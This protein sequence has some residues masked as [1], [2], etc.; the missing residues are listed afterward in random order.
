MKGCFFSTTLQ[1]QACQ[2]GETSSHLHFAKVKKIA[3]VAPAF[4]KMVEGNE[5][6]TWF[7]MQVW[8][9]QHLIHDFKESDGVI[10]DA[11]DPPRY[12]QALP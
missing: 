9:L 8:I 5:E 12:Q 10:I 2:A 4:F 3:K 11:H 7:K 6:E 1:H